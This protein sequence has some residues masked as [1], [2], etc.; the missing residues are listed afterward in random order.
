MRTI[1]AT[2][3][4]GDGLKWFNGLYLDVTEAVGARVGAGGF[5]DPAWLTQL[6]LQFAR[7]YLRAL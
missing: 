2:C 7:Q 1:A 4:D 6:D 5:T 3:I